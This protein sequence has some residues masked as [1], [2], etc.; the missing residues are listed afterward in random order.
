MD[1]PV[2]DPYLGPLSTLHKHYEATEHPIE[3]HVS[4]RHAT[5]RSDEP[6]EPT[7]TKYDVLVTP[8]MARKEVVEQEPIPVDPQGAKG[9]GWFLTKTGW[10]WYLGE[11]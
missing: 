1:Q 5:G 3:H 2:S 4:L 11:K 9:Q 10:L 6:R 8:K 7:V